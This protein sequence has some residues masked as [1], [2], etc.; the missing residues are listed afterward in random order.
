METCLNRYWQHQAM[1]N[2]NTETDTKDRQIHKVL[3]HSYEKFGSSILT[4][5]EQEVLRML[6]RR[7]SPTEIGN[8]LNISSA[9]IL[10]HRR[11]IYKKLSVRS[12]SE[13]FS[14][15]L[16]SLWS[17]GN[18]PRFDDPWQCYLVETGP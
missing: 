9:I 11:N 6:L 13:L 2:T 18:S 3:S 15:F 8:L 5:R 17:V 1:V 10:V 4:E 7:F 16:D 14:L 12:Q